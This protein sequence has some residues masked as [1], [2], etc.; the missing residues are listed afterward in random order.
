MTRD[1]FPGMAALPG[2]QN[3]YAYTG[4][5]P[6][7][8]TDPSGRI[9]PILIAAGVGAILGGGAGGAGYV[10]AHPGQRPEDYLQSGGFWR[11][12]GVGALSGGVAGAVG[13]WV[14]GIALGGGLGGAIAGGVLSGA[15]SGGAGQITANLLTPC[16]NWYDNV[17]EATIFGG[18]IGGITG[19]VGYS[20]GRWTM[21]RANAVPNA[22][23]AASP[24]L[25]APPSIQRHHIFPQ[26]FRGWFA[27]RGIDI[28]LY[29]VELSRGTHL[30]G[31]H[32]QGGFVGPGNVSLPG[33]WNAHWQEFINANP[34]ATAK[35]VYQFAG[36]LMDQFGLGGLPIVPY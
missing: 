21:P 15:A 7:N 27:Q 24:P 23:N 20:I 1:P 9:A 26:T 35:E 13:F 31:V 30:S 2:T 25:L 11:A 12:V 29:T 33:Q 6:V 17:A 4:N 8:L 34:N 14:G 10:M 3:A 18:V 32:G 19:G 5:N 36:Q 22:E 16:A 28:D